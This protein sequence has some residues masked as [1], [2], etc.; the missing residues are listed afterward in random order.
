FGPT[1]AGMRN[2]WLTC[3]R[4]FSHLRRRR[5]QTVLQGRVRVRFHNDTSPRRC[6]RFAME[7][8]GGYTNVQL[9]G[10]NNETTTS[11]WCGSLGRDR[12]L[13]RRLAGAAL[14]Q[15]SGGGDV[16]GV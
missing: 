8:A 4:S 5:L 12:G 14:C 2:V 15:G 11:S 3:K 1:F 9:Q 16:S 13:G 6:D 10:T 7:P